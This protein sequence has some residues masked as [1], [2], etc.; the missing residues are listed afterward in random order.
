MPEPRPTLTRTRTKAFCGP[1][2]VREHTKIALAFRVKANGHE[3]S[4]R[5][6]STEP[7]S[8]DEGAERL[9]AWITRAGIEWQGTTGK[10]LA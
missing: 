1:A 9:I 2:L 6:S 5:V 8:G 3:D 4:K 7:R 10:V